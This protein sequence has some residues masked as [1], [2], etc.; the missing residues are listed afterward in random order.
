MEINKNYPCH[1]SNYKKGR[2]SSIKYIVIHYVGASGSALNNV[3]YYGDTANIGASAHYYVGHVKENGAVYQSVEDKDCAWHCGAPNGVYYHEC[4]NDSSIGIEICCHKDKNG[5]WYF[6][7]VTIDKAVELT[8]FLMN[9]YGIAKENVIRHYDVTHK[10]CPA[11]FVLNNAAWES[12]K[13]RIAKKV[14]YTSVNDIVWELANRGIISDKKLWLEKLEFDDN[15]Y[16]LA[17]KVV[18]YLASL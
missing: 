7:D 3:Q 8:R 2:K 5:T 16:W 6:D 1:T 11:P 13:E 18:N 17:R 15:S 10:T 9:K 14:E 12:F 4:R